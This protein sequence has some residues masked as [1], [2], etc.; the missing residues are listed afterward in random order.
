M[1]RWCC[2]ARVQS[3]QIWLSC[4]DWRVLM[5]SW[6]KR[7]QR[8]AERM[9][10]VARFDNCI[11]FDHVHTENTHTKLS[12]QFGVR[13]MV[14]WLLPGFMLRWV[15]SFLALQT[16]VGGLEAEKGELPTQQRS[17]KLG[18][19]RTYQSFLAQV[20]WTMLMSV[21]RLQV[22]RSK[23]IKFSLVY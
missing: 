14:G 16:M 5:T 19:F 11:L 10:V 23:C 21:M 9:A 15:G 22:Q 18:H 7:A 2:N 8:C 20:S 4:Y 6:S 17:S 12:R 3:K 1:F 13:G